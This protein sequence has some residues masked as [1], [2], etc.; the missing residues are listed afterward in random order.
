ME[1][2]GNLDTYNCFDMKLGLIVLIASINITYIARN[3]YHNKHNNTFAQYVLS[4][5]TLYPLARMY[6]ED[7]PILI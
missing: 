2:R 1:Q 5:Q 7:L 4:F 3:R 6:Y